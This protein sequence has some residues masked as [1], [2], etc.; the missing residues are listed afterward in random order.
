MPKL[1]SEN[2]ARLQ[3]QSGGLWRITII[4]PGRGS[5]GV[6][7]PEIL[8]RDAA[9]AFPKG[10]KL[11]FGHP[12]DWESAGERDARDQWAYLESDAWWD[13]EK[14]EV[15]AD[16]RVLSHWAE[17]VNSLGTQASLSIYAWVESD[18]QDN[19]TALLGHVTNSVDIV[20]YPGRPGSGLDRKIE[21]AREAAPKT[22]VEASAGKEK[23]NHM[24]E[25][26]VE[27][28]V[29]RELESALAPVIAFVNE[30]KAAKEAEA[31]AQVDA[32]ALE[33]A[34][35]EAITRYEAA[36]AAI[37]AAEGLL[38]PSVKSLKARAA[39]GEDITS[40]IAEAV[41]HDKTYIEAATQR[42]GE[43]ADEDKYVVGRT[44]KAGETPK[45]A[46]EALKG[47]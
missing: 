42:A 41:E 7:A 4:T 12:K 9:T 43:S 44:H 23:E 36:T 19:I 3:E 26:A 16:A 2:T 20:S 33:T 34:A 5:S 38:E 40:A 6:Y 37:E 46:S 15:V 22:T 25:K 45:S 14:E 27:A 21:A 8:A 1:V 32:E 18:E 31:Q 28:L 17:V 24:D 39:K 11:W 30:S 35:A 13:A 29:K 10:T 47:W